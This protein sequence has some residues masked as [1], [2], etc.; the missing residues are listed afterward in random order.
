MAID[1]SASEAP[2]GGSVPPPIRANGCRRVTLDM[3]AWCDRADSFKGLPRGTAKPL[4]YLYAF[5]EA[6][7][8]L[9]LSAHAYKLVDWLVRLSKPQDW[10]EGS[11]PIVWPSLRRQVEFLG[12]SE[13]RV[14]ALNR[15]LQEAGIL[16]MRDDPQ[17]RRYGHRDP[18]TGR[19]TRAFGFD[20]SLLMERHEEFKKIAADAQ[21][22]RNRM[23]KLR[24]RKGLARNAIAQ[25]AQELGVQGHDSERLQELMREAADLIKAGSRC[26]RSDELGL[27]VNALERRRDEIRQM[28]RDLM[29]PVEKSP[30]GD[31]N[32]THSTTT[33]LIEN[34]KKDTVIAANKSS[35]VEVA[36]A[37]P[38]DQAAPRP[39]RVFPESLQITPATLVELAPRLSPYM[40]PRFSDKSWPAV[41]EAA[42]FLSGEMGVNRTLWARACE[43]MGREYAAVAMAIVSTKQQGQEPGQ[44]QS[45][46]GGY[47]AGMLKKFEKNPHDLC[48]SR[49]LWRL[50]DEAWGKD[51]HSERRKIEKQRRVEMRTKKSLHPD[52]DLPEE[53]PSREP[54]RTSVGGFRPIGS[55]LPQQPTTYPVPPAPPRPTLSLPST[56][57]DWK[58]S[59]ELLEAEQRINAWLTNGGNKSAPVNGPATPRKGGNS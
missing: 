10:E 39:D 36:P 18:K 29:K 5:K 8:Y 50:K 51:G 44:I 2:Q 55:V 47:F 45:T 26:D 12:L 57:K 14:Q 35:S 53:F 9:G 17:G 16:V 28:L 3:R 15:V 34:L 25:A 32:D 52:L 42:L 27:A 22:E 58:P 46:P 4:T 19:I 56:S 23:K 13:R 7:T 20:L 37:V 1:N 6:S 24:Q 59:Q 43:V 41:V 48:L 31:E 54:A 33:T 38:N 49:T 11:R 30:M 40:P 21:V